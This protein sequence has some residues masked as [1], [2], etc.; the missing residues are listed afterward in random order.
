MMGL[1]MQPR[2]RNAKQLERN[3]LKIG[4]TSN[5]FP[6]RRVGVLLSQERSEQFD[7]IQ[8]SRSGV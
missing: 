6:G 1:A 3:Q 7:V 4:L 5:K 2:L 8:G